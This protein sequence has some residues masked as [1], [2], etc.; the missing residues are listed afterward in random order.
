M[1][2]GLVPWLSVSENRVRWEQYRLMN[3]EWGERLMNEEWGDW[4][5][6]GD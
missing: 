1:G 5:R 4:E 3:E 2:C 6:V